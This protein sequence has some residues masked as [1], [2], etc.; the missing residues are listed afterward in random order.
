MSAG[1][2][3][4]RAALGVLAAALLVSLALPWLPVGDPSAA[5]LPDQLR[6]PDGSHWFGT[7]ALGRDV[8][9]RTLFGVRSSL[10]IGLLAAAVSLA[11]GVLVGAVAGFSRPRVD[12]ALMRLVDVLYGIPFI[13]LV[14]FLLAVLREHEPWLRAH[15]ITRET[16]LYLVVG[17]TSWLTMARLVRNEVVRLKSLPFVE[18]ARALGL[19]ARRVLFR[20]VLPNAYGVILVALTLTIPSIVLYEAFLSFLGLG[21]EPPGVSLGLLA[22]EGIE[23]IT[24]VHAAW[25][26]IVFPGGALALILLALSL[27]GD[28]ARDRFDP[29]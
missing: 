9:A 16:V 18:S 2:V 1:R 5:A 6:P 22:A 19:P 15:G 14:I 24:P 17:G 21:I 26:L 4:V 29:R 11:L 25:W 10:W 12:A 20:H 13:C 7:D 27:V 8:L 3:A 28:A 23:S